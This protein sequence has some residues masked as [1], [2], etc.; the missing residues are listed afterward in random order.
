MNRNIA[1]LQ[2]KKKS[3]LTKK[4]RKSIKGETSTRSRVGNGGWCSCGN[5]RKITSENKNLCCQEMNLLGNR[6]DLESEVINSSK[7][8]SEVTIFW[9]LPK[10]SAVPATDLFHIANWVM[11]I[12]TEIAGTKLQCITE[13]GSFEPVCL[14]A[15]IFRIAL[16]GNHQVRNERLEDYRSND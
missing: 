5:C 12:I 7:S 10:K 2:E 13:H 8:V 9:F 4:L 14:L 3:L 6:L 16:F 15:K 11:R 1:R